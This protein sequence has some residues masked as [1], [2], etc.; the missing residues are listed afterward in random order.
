MEELDPTLT[1]E[2]PQQE[3]ENDPLAP[4]AALSVDELMQSGEEQPEAV[5]APQEDVT[6]KAVLEAGIYVSEEP[7]TVAQISASL[8]EPAE[9]IQTLLDQ[10]MGEFEAAGHGLC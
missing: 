8:Q 7:L 10:L 6:L 9:R 3:Q 1:G 4:E 5:A 2:A